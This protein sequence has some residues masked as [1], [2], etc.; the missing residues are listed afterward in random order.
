MID[1]LKYFEKLQ[2]LFGSAAVTFRDNFIC[3]DGILTGLNG[4]RRRTEMTETETSYRKSRWF[5][6]SPQRAF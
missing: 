3:L 4:T 6:F 2:I 5:L 1:S